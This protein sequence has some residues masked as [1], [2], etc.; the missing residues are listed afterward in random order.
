MKAKGIVAVLFCL[1]FSRATALAGITL[2]WDANTEADLAGYK[3]YYGSTCDDLSGTELD[4][5]ASPITIPLTALTN[6]NFPS[7]PVTT[8]TT[9]FFCFKLTAYDLAGNES[10]FS[11]PTSG[12]AVQKVGG[13][14]ATSLDLTG[15]DNHVYYVEGG[16]T[17]EVTSEISHSGGTSMKICGG[18]FNGARFTVHGL[19]VGEIVV[20]LGWF[21]VRTTQGTS[22]TDPVVLRLNGTNQTNWSRSEQLVYPGVGWKYFAASKIVAPEDVYGMDVNIFN[23]TSAEC[24]YVDDVNVVVGKVVYYNDFDNLSPGISGWGGDVYYVSDGGTIIETT[25]E[26]AFKGTSSLKIHGNT[27][28]AARFT[29]HGLVPG[30]TVVASGSFKSLGTN[31]VQ[32]R[33]NSTEKTDWNWGDFIP[34]SD[35]QPFEISKIVGANSMDFN[36]FTPSSDTLYLDSLKIRLGKLVYSSKFETGGDLFGWDNNVSY[37]GG[38]ANLDLNSVIRFSGTSSLRVW[39]GIRNA[40]RLLF[41]GLLPGDNVVFSGLLASAGPEVWIRTNSTGLTDWVQT[42]II[43]DRSWQLFL[44]EKIIGGICTDF[45]VFSIPPDEFYLEDIRI[46]VR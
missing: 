32:V 11:N 37:I 17:I 8:S 15:W 35:W 42:S 20:F 41:C 3:M 44:Q 28:N 7:L 2:Q 16:A 10:G 36:I 19:S 25:S 9:R 18:G 5:G 34:N 4:Q 22:G 24:I 39:G 27:W 23:T 12:K 45:N 33:L 43:P 21:T 26:D 13:S 40:A 38:G 46:E 14:F 6:P 30:D 1:L 29:I 31:V